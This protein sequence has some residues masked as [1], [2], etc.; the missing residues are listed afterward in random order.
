MRADEVVLKMMISTLPNSLRDVQERLMKTEHE[1]NLE[2]SNGAASPGLVPDDAYTLFLA[3]K[4]FSSSPR[5]RSPFKAA[6]QYIHETAC[7]DVERNT[8]FTASES[9]V[10]GRT[11]P[12][13][14]DNAHQSPPVMT[15]ATSH[16]HH[17][18]QNGEESTTANVLTV[19]EVYEG[20]QSELETGDNSDWSN[21]MALDENGCWNEEALQNM[22]ATVGFCMGDLTA[23]M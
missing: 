17:E 14:S 15:P 16:Q 18:H 22:F 19:G 9:R 5:E 8:S 13:N 1:V 11:R 12:T 2:L 7:N 4:T 21:S 23:F 20:C 3:Q 10:Q 6:S